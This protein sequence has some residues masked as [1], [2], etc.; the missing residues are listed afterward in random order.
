YYRFFGDVWSTPALLAARQTGH[1]WG[2]VGSLVTAGLLWLVVDWPFAGWAAIRATRAA[3][4]P[5]PRACAIAAAA[6]IGAVTVAGAALSAPRVLAAAP[7]DQM[8]RAR[9]IVEQLG[10][11]GYHAYDTLTYVRSTWLR[12]PATATMA[13]EAAAWFRDRAPLRA[14]GASFGVARG[15]HLRV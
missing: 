6:A 13:A 1:V 4:W 8:F 3:S 11:F 12:R 14:G 7:L 9:S 2:S 15:P 5:L 10:P